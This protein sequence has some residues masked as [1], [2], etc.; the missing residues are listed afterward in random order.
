MAEKLDPEEVVP[1]ADLA[2]S[3]MWKI[4]AQVEVLERMG[5]CLRRKYRGKVR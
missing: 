5:S 2:I 1:I 3:S 4:A